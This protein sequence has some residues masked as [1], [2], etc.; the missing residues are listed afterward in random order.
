MNCDLT[1]LAPCEDLYAFRD[2]LHQALEHIDTVPQVGPQQ[3]FSRRLREP[4]AKVDEADRHVM[5]HTHYGSLT[6]TK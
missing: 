3:T 5:R 1:L 4:Q 2:R 6:T